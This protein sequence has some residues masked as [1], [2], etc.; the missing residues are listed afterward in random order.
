MN[1]NERVLEAKSIH[2]FAW[3]FLFKN[4]KDKVV[5][6]GD[7]E[8]KLKKVGWKKYKFLF[9]S[10]CED[11]EDRE[12]FVAR[13][14]QDAALSQYLSKSCKSIYIDNDSEMCSI[15]KIKKFSCGKYDYIIEKGNQ[16]YVLPIV[17]IELHVYKYGIG[18]LFIQLINNDYNNISDIKI[19]NDLGRRVLLPFIPNKNEDDTSEET[20]G[21]SLTAD[22]LGIVGYKELGKV[23][24]EKKSIIN[25]KKAIVDFYSGQSDG[26]KKC[27]EEPEFLQT[28]INNFNEEDEINIQSAID[29]RM[30]CSCVIRDEELVDKIKL[31]EFCNED[32]YSIVF[33]DSGDATCKE[34]EMR[35]GL[36]EKAC[37]KR[38]QNY[39][40]MYAFTE[41]S[42]FCITSGDSKINDSVVKPFISLYTYL[43]SLVLLQRVGIAKFSEEAGLL[44]RGIGNKGKIK[45]WK[46][47]QL[48][49][50][51]EQYIEFENQIMLLEASNQ[52]QGIEMYQKLQ[53]Q[54]LICDE[55]KILDAQMQGLYEVAN[56]SASIKLA[57]AANKLAWI[58]IVIGVLS[59]IPFIIEII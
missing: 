44:A 12:D 19:I 36:M 33:V 57:D 42:A 26:I 45:K 24:N 25:Y 52:Q 7:L 59:L 23:I 41:Y 48:I 54:F 3:P 34:E 31:A 9:D 4:T 16:K 30:F 28:I 17:E 55:K 5:N 39:G 14:K 21:F 56:M 51:Q 32:S 35:K 47:K 15:Y 11:Y 43:I 22:K 29:D 38:W 13:I 40:T 6:L 37:Y 58:A 8:S 49:E 53:G 10:K 46:T 27:L 50:L 18:I 1:I 20:I 2:T